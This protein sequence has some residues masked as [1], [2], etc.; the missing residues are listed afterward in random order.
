[1]LTR[2]WLCAPVFNA[3]LADKAV[4][5]G[6]DLAL[7]DLEDSVPAERKDEAREALRARF[8]TPVQVATGIRINVLSSSHGLRDLLCVLDHGIAP[9]VLM[10]PKTALPDEVNLASALLRERGVTAT[11]IFAV[12]ETV[13]S[14]W[15]LRTMTS[16]P[17]GLS[18]IVFG[19]ADFAADLGVAP[20]ATD[21]AFAQQD[22]ALAARRFGLVAIDSPCFQLRGGGRL[23]AELRD[24]R[25]LGFTGKIAIHPGQVAAIN[26]SFLPSAQAVEHA[27]R[28]VDAATATPDAILEV[29]DGMVGPPFVK[30]ARQVLATAPAP[31][32]RR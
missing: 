19:A 9:D 20:T 11:K 27:R 32:A 7:F 29:D 22:I 1:M 10:L 28:L 21:L 17:A 2:S 8:A 26:Q 25:R 23:A 5:V 31:T 14:L 4:E 16:A 13:S 30:H 15:S 12:I 18:G 24:A 6:A 3:R